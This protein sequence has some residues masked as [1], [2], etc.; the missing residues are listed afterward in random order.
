M[1]AEGV[2]DGAGDGFIG[3]EVGFASKRGESRLVREED[4]IGDGDEGSSF[5]LLLSPRALTCIR[6]SIDLADYTGASERVPLGKKANREAADRMRSGMIEMIQDVAD[7]GEEGDDAESREW[8]EA[9]IRRGEGRRVVT[10][11]KSVSPGRG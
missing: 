9:Q 4:E 11:E 7:E 3:L 1:R 5:A 2:P 10:N 8:E 6:H